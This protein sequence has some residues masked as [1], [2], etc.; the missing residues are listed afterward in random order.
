MI[1]LKISGHRFLTSLFCFFFCRLAATYGKATQVI[2]KLISSLFLYSVREKKTLNK[3]SPEG[4]TTVFSVSAGSCIFIHVERLSL[5]ADAAWTCSDSGSPHTE[6]SLRLSLSG[7][8][9]GV[10][11]A[12]RTA[13]RTAVLTQVYTPVISEQRLPSSFYFAKK[14]EKKT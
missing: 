2:I 4:Q 3:G 8:G 12:P 6:Y 10:S 13:P 14:K 5:E 11:G 1:I 9:D 7:D